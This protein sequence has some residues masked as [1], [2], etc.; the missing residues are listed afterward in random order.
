MVR[1]GIIRLISVIEMSIGGMTIFGLFTAPL[2]FSI[3]K[4]SNVFLFVMI[5]ALASLALGIGL[6]GY[7]AWARTLLIF[8]S[9]YIV[10]T[11]VLVLLNLLYFTCEFITAI[12]EGVKNIISIS[13][14]T[15][16]VLFLS[17]KGTAILF[18]HEDRT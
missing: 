15:F 3:S 12:P 5:T 2:M 7:R 4:P 18:Y 1:R 14:H 17:A 13:Y 11:K 16:L 9:G 10:L 8:F 6:F